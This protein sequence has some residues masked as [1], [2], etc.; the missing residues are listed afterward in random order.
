[1]AKRTARRGP[2]RTVGAGAEPA[3]RRDA[4]AIGKRLREL[5]HARSLSLAQVSRLAGLSQGYLSQVER[6]RATPSTTALSRLSEV[7]DVPVVH[8]FEPSHERLPDQYVVRRDGRRTILYPGSKVKNE[9]LVPDL[10]GKLEAIYFRAP[11]KTRS[12]VYKHEGEEFGFVLKGRLRVTVGDDTFVLGRGDSISL[13]SHQP[14][15]WEALGRGVEALWV[16]T[17]PS[18]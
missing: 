14:H 7:L 11:G 3:R 9:L 10:R 18:W 17:P 4:L 1:M 5:R 16:A 15:F 13:P 8:F 6:D 2:G 12:P